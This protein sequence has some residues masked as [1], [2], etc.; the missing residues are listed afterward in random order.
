MITR[1]QMNA[2]VL[3]GGKTRF[4]VV[5]ALVEVK[6]PMTAY[7]IAMSKGLDPAATY[8][9]LTEF[10]SFGMVESET[11]ERNQTVYKLSKG[12]GEAAAEFLRALMQST[13]TSKSHDIEE[14]LSPEMQAERIAKMVQVDKTK[15]A[16]SPFVRTTERK[17][18]RELMSK[19]TS[20]ELSAL[21]ESS[22][23]AFN[24]L[25]KRQEDGVFALKA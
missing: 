21:I 12:T 5:D 4:R 17:S 15:I 23:I 24:E 25:F 9:C 10:S 1:I 16:N 8:R 6:Q 20:G 13:S 14:W 11:T 19:R 7:Q 22:K 18:I 3:L 2:E